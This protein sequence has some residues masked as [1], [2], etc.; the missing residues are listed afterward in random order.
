MIIHIRINE[1]N[2]EPRQGEKAKELASMTN[3][4]EG[5]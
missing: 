1:Q 2:K 3:L 5:I 4:V